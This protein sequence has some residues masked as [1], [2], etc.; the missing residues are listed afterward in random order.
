MEK[1]GK[2]DL[3]MHTNISDGTDSPE[4]LL[5]KVKENGIGLFSVTDHDAVNACRI[6]REILP[7]DGPAFLTGVEFSCK[8]EDGKYHILGYG[9]DPDEERFAEVRETSHDYR[10]KKMQARLDY[11]EK[12]HEIYFC[13]EEKDALLAL[14]NPGKPHLGELMAARGYAPNKDAA[15]EK[16]LNGVRLSSGTYY[17]SPKEA[18][19]GILAAGG[20]P[21]LAHPPLGSGSDEIKKEELKERLE[22]LTKLGLQGVE[23]FYPTFT[24]EQREAVLDLAD[25]F[26]LY[27]TAGS[28]YHGTNKDNK[29]GFTGLADAAEGPDGLRRFLEDVSKLIVR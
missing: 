7:T 23:G 26:K 13:K 16:Y 11:L 6:I 28:D 12:V 15:I 18:I 17:L 21:V 29:L 25:H 5:A 24:E 8:D 20:I 2:I 19:E 14:E 9:F 10:V 1:F 22:K 27:V 4:E 3:H